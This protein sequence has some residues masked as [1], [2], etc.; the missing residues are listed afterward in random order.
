MR[1]GLTEEEELLFNLWEKLTP[2]V[3]WHG[4]GASADDSNKMVLE[5]LGGF[6][7]HVVLVFLGGNQFIGHVGCLNGSLV[8]R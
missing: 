3:D 8:L 4:W 5:G 7:C 1:S 6:F 2:K